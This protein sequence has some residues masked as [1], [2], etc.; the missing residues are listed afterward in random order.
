M[1]P[2]IPVRLSDVPSSLAVVTAALLLGCGGT[3]E[4]KTFQ[5][6]AYSSAKVRGDVSTE[7]ASDQEVG[8]GEV[9]IACPSAD[10]LSKVRVDGGDT[11]T[12]DATAV[13]DAG[14]TARLH[15]PDLERVELD[16]PEGDDQVA[17]VLTGQAELQLDEVVAGDVLIIA[18]GGSDAEIGT[19]TAGSADFDYAGGGQLW[20]GASNADRIGLTASGNSQITFEETDARRFEVIA[21]GNADVLASGECDEAS[22]A[23]TGSAVIDAAD[24]SAEEADVEADGNAA[25]SL[26]VTGSVTG[27]AD[28]S[29][30]VEILGDPE[31][32]IS[33]SAA[34]SAT[35]GGSPL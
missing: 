31:G 21:G 29:A 14:C 35:I 22:I 23:A 13:A 7:L 1:T 33:V 15:G 16:D 20:V 19:L 12:I 6:G 24:L 34:A 17:L 3:T 32:S 26:T 5:T 11:L 30:S 27:S 25:I 9:V 4:S 8:P 18:R 28:G 10:A 2:H